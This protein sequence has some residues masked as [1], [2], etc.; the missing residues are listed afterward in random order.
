VQ[1]FSADLLD[2]GAQAATARSRH[3]ALRRFSAWL[4]EEGELDAN[5]LLGVNRRSSTKRLSMP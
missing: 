1:A 2:A 5:P 4:A 3:M